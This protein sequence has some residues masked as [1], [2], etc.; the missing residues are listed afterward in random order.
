M[1]IIPDDGFAAYIQTSEVKDISEVEKEL[2]FQNEVK[3]ATGEG[4]HA[5]SGHVFKYDT[6]KKSLVTAIKPKI[7]K[8]KIR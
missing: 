8:Q 4:R 2:Q 3:E 7:E 5:L 1:V 6:V